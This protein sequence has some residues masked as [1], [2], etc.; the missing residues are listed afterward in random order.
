[1]FNP[2]VPYRDFFLPCICLWQI[3]PIQTCLC[4]VV[5]P[6]FFSTSPASSWPLLSFGTM[7]GTVQSHGPS[8]P[9]FRC[10]IFRLNLDITFGCA[11]Q[12]LTNFHSHNL[13][14]SLLKFPKWRPSCGIIDILFVYISIF[15]YCIMCIDCI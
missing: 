3:S 10:N 11:N 7:F 1:M 5:G 9:S 14:K 6:G 8:L 13:I 4:V 12:I 2:G 15:V